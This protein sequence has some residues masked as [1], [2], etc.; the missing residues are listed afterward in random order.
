MAYE[1]DIET[2]P[3]P[4]DSDAVN[5]QFVE[6]ALGYDLDADVV[7]VMSVMRDEPVGRGADPT[8]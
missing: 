4:S 5:V 7:V 6:F 8:G 2:D 3:A 1:F